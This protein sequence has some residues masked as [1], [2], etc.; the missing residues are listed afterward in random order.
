MNSIYWKY[1]TLKSSVATVTITG[2]ADNYNS[3]VVYVKINGTVHNN[4]QTL[5]LPFGTVIECWTTSD[6]DIYSGVGYFGDEGVYLN[7]TRVAHMVAY[8]YT[9][10]CDCTIYFDFWGSGGWR[11]RITET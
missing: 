11:I 8:N 1:F 4:P 2:D 10:S 9:V 3:P 7:G 5:S 6:S